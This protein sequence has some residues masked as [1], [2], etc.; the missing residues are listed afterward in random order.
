MSHTP[1][2]HGCIVLCLALSGLQEGGDALPAADAAIT[3]A[4]LEHHVRFL[5]S[6]ELEGRAPLTRGMERAAQ[7]LARALAA[8]G[9]EPAGEDGSYFQTTGLKRYEY[10]SPPR[11]VLTDE[12]G[13]E[14][15]ARHGTDFSLRVRG[16]A[17]S[18]ETLPLRFFYD[19]NHSRMPLTGNSSEALYFSA[20][21]QDKQRILAEKGIPNLHDWGLEIEVR[22]GEKP[23]R[24]R[25]SLAPR[26]ALPEPEACE[27]VEL[28]G[29]LC[30]DFERR[31]FTHVRLEIEEVLAPY[32]DRN[33]V[34]R[35]RG[36]GTPEEP[37]L[38]SEVV[39]LSAHYDHLGIRPPP[40]GRERED[41]LFNG[42][43]DDASGCAALLELAQA[44][45]AGAR[46]V[47]TLVF[48]FTTGEESGGRGI[49][50]YLGGPAEPLGATVADLNLEMLGRPDGL[51][52]GPGRLWLTGH[53]RTNLGAAW[54]ELG[55]AIVADPRPDEGF[56]LRSDN[57]ALA[58]EGVVAQ[59]LSSFGGHKEYHS[60]RDEPDTLDYDHLEAATRV[61]FAA[62]RTL[63]D[64]SLRPAWREDGQPKKPTR[65]E[66]RAK[67]G[68]EGGRRRE[69]GRQDEDG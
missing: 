14:V 42:A 67:K 27:L 1:L 64:G 34:G 61:A 2:V 3:R 54:E 16:T 18:T 17:S 23:G 35:I 10:R 15:E 30:P 24:A 59:S 52:G 40:R 44:F 58:V 51:I 22:P 68:D 60:P 45:A 65:L 62:A 48:L 39:I 41:S 53:E 47:R 13:A 28:R 7:Y 50:R 12:S 5:A 4:E 38:A 25:D 36:V 56:F 19:Y 20:T 63:A 55:L 43:D 69:E 49:A 32:E 21:K 57:Y 37:G 29:P 9:A 33:V 8:A 66:G 11:L 26:L 31:R 6:D 46:P